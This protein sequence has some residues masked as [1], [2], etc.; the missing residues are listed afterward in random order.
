LAASSW[1]TLGAEGEEVVRLRACRCACPSKETS[2][3]YDVA[4]R[5]QQALDPSALIT[6][7]TALHALNAA[8]EDCRNA[9]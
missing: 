4:F 3:N 7:S 9:G 5:Y 8:V 1:L 6:L 2:M